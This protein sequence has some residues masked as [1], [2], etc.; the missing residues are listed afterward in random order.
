MHIS[1]IIAVILA[2]GVG[3]GGGYIVASVTADTV[4]KPHPEAAMSMENIMVSMNAGLEGTSGD[5]F[6]RAFLTEMTLHHRGAIQMAKLA[7]ENAKHDEVKQMAATIIAAQDAEIEQMQAWLS[8]WY[9]GMSTSS[10]IDIG[11]DGAAHHAQ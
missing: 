4:E 2:L 6:D 9:G 3:V 8:S 1:T 5:N 10:E 11:S 7:L